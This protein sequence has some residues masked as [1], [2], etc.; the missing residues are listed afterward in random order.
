LGDVIAQGGRQ[1]G[2]Y[3]QDKQ[4]ERDK[5]WSLRQL[6]DW[7]NQ[8]TAELQKRDETEDT[9]EGFTPRVMEDYDG[10]IDG[11]LD[12]APSDGA[13]QFLAL[14]MEE[15]R[16]AVYNDALKIETGKTMAAKS[17]D[18]SAVIENSANFALSK[19]E[20]GADAVQ[21]ALSAVR[22][23]GLPSE[24]RAEAESKAVNTV[25][26]SWVEGMGKSRS[27]GPY[28][29]LARLQ[30]GEFDKM[31]AP[32]D[33]RVL[34]NMLETD[35]RQGEA[36]S[37]EDANADKRRWAR[38]FEDF[39]KLV[40]D[41]NVA[42]TE[43]VD[44]F[45]PEM[46]DE[47]FG[48]DPEAAKAAKREMEYAYKAGAVVGDPAKK[49]P[50]LKREAAAMR[51]KVADDSSSYGEVDARVG[52]VEAAIARK[53][54]ALVADGG[55]YVQESPVIQSV[56]EQITLLQSEM[57]AETDPGKQAV[58]QRQINAQYDEWLDRTYK[59]QLDNG[60]FSPEAPKA[61]VMQEVEAINNME[62]AKLPEAMAMLRERFPTNWHR[63]A[64]EVQS[65]LQT[66][67]RA[68]FSLPATPTSKLL[69]DGH[70]MSNE[71][72]LQGIPD[73][74][75]RALKGLF[76]EDPK[77]KAFAQT[78]YSS[79]WGKETVE[80]WRDATLRA[81][82]IYM[83]QQ[84][85]SPTAAWERARDDITSEYTVSHIAGKP[86]RMPRNQI[87]GGD[88]QKNI[89]LG[90]YAVRGN[91]AAPENIWLP[92]GPGGTSGR[93]HT[94]EQ[95]QEH[96]RTNAYFV[97]SGD[98]KGLI[99]FDSGYPVHTIVNGRP[100][101]VMYTWEDLRRTGQFRADQARKLHG[102]PDWYKGRGD[103]K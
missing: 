27:V 1:L 92:T 12:A 14:K 45:S 7:K 54:A 64:G 72:L 21:M 95:Y 79:K 5:L 31:L 101:Y 24:M 20:L 51:A 3:L 23:S 83:K 15:F 38:S 44:R 35:I 61:F 25:A 60:A 8:W 59:E 55:Q 99:M 86:Y 43:D 102:R 81:S 82:A 37:K 90:A 89:E 63:L 47:M 76:N 2:A 77:M 10:G 49:L 39:K 78:A 65:K 62:P 29:T 56:K 26:R 6:G 98:E 85:L 100:Q 17:K 48:D 50:D 42:K 71:D 80:S 22:S 93:F 30:K 69:A 41:G 16:G 53:E 52:A 87:G 33:R 13:R 66:K 19:P 36:Q 32:T 4:D 68:L 84:G 34:E 11:V 46:I 96:L 40:A 97:T 67:V 18:M 75:V 70:K 9:P 58:L 74:D 57:D 94:K 103:V 28:R 73:D 91:F 88:Q